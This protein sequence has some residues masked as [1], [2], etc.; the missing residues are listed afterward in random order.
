MHTRFLC[1]AFFEFTAVTSLAQ[2]LVLSMSTSYTQI[3]QS[4]DVSIQGETI[5]SSLCHRACPE[6]QQ[7][8][9]PVSIHNDLFGYQCFFVWNL[10]NEWTPPE[11][12]PEEISCSAVCGCV[13][14]ATIIF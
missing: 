12:M 5:I 2:D 9:Y 4:S 6:L 14:I 1:F 10:L 13:Y 8:F 11:A 7:T 3:C